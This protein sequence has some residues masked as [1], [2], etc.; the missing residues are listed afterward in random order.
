MRF[1]PIN[2]YQV[3]LKNDLLKIGILSL[4]LVIIWIIISVNNISQ[5]STTP[6]E[7]QDLL[8]EFDPSLNIEAVKSLN[9]RY[10]P[11]DQFEV[12]KNANNREETTPVRPRP[13]SSPSP[14][15]NSQE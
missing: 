1:R 12:R 9:G 3:N 14:S 2:I 6:P 4:V 8:T 15:L 11:P 10:S 5:K 7:V 13:I